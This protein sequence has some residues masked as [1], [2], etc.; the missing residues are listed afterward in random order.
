MMSER[1]G[2]GLADGPGVV[3]FAGPDEGRDPEMHGVAG[4]TA[5]PLELIYAGDR[6]SAITWRG[7][8]TKA[9]APATARARRQILSRLRT[10][11][12]WRRLS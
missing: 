12:I 1:P 9:R 11:K 4:V 7:P 5:E 3:V 6:S 2:H 10:R 8:I